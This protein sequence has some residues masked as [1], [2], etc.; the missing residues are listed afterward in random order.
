[1][2]IENRQKGIKQLAV[3]AMF[4][5]IAFVC[6]LVIKIPVQ[7]L[8]LDIKDSV[9]I[10]CG[11]LF[12]PLSALAISIIVPLLE[13]G[14]GLSGT[15]Y[16]GLIMNILSS[17]SFSLVASIIYKYKKTLYGAIVGLISG[18]LA[19]TAVMMIANLLITPYYMG[20]PTAAV[21]AL[22]PKLLLPFNLVKAVLN[23]AI[24]LLLYKPISKILKKLGIIGLSNRIVMNNTK[25]K[26]RNI[27]ITSIAAAIIVLSLLII[28]F[29]LK[30]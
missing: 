5:A 10:L 24:V 16:Y 17:L 25:T 11:L 8:T 12:G 27:V 6:M 13:L 3:I 18:V 23:A 9:I 28:F 14:L 30:A 7:F 2:N 20:A 26:T 19:M 21:A 22:I 4:C 29:V 15:G 1:M